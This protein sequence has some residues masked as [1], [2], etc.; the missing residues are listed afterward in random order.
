MKNVFALELILLMV[1]IWGEKKL[2]NV[3]KNILLFID[4]LLTDFLIGEMYAVF[5]LLQVY[6]VEG[7]V[8][9]LNTL[10]II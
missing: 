10:S 1:S 3:I 7:L 6:L 5:L 8:A 9:Y 2:K 4:D